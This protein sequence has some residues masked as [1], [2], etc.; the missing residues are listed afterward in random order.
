MKKVFGFDNV[1]GKMVI[2]AAEA[3]VVKTVFNRVAGYVEHPPK[4]LVEPVLESALKNGEIIT[5][6]EAEKRVPYSAILG[7]VARELN[8]ELEKPY[9]GVISTE[10]GAEPSVSETIIS[11]ELWDKVQEKIQRN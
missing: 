1:D 4:I 11:K 3:D 8:V 7:Y 9:T 10:K 2:N 5:Y 6:E